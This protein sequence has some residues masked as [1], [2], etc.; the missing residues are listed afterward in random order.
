[1]EVLFDEI[2]KKAPANWEEVDDQICIIIA[3]TGCPEAHLSM[4]RQKFKTF[5][6]DWKFAES[7]SVSINTA[8]K[9]RN[10]EVDRVL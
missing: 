4:A 2:E 7:N 1:M 6:V 5:N 8:I 9:F 3:N 10:G